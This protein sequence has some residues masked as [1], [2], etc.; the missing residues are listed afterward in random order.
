MKEYIDYLTGHGYNLEAFV[1]GLMIVFDQGTRSRTGKLLQPKFGFLKLVMES[2]NRNPGR[3][4]IFVPV[5]IGYD[6][7]S[8]HCSWQVIET[9][10]YVNELLGTP[11]KKESLFQLANNINILQLK[12]GRVDV[13]FGIPF[14]LRSF[15]EASLVNGKIP[16]NIS[17]TARDNH[18]LQSLGYK[19]L[20]DINQITSIM[21]TALVGTILLTLRGRGVGRDELIRKVKWLKEEIIMRGGKVAES[22]RSSTEIL[23]DRAIDVLKELVGQR[24]DIL[25]SVYYPAKRFEL[26]YYRNQVIH[27]FV[28]EC[29]VAIAMYSVIKVGGPVR[30]QR[31]PIKSQLIGDVTFLSRLLR[32]EFV[33]GSGGINQNLHLTIEKLISSNVVIIGKDDSKPPG[34]DLWV[35]LS[36]EER[37]TGRETFDFYCFLMWPFIETYWLCAVSL[38]TILPAGSSSVFWIDSRIFIDRSQVFGKTLYHEGD[39][40]YF[41][42][43]NKETIENAIGWFKQ[44]GII[45]VHKGI[46]PP[47]SQN[48]EPSHLSKSANTTWIALTKEWYLQIP[49]DCR[50]P[51]ESLPD[52]GLDAAVD[53][54]KNADWKG[55]KGPFQTVSQKYLFDDE[56]SVATT[57]R[58]QRGSLDEYYDDETS[59]ID[60][61]DKLSTM[62]KSS[63]RTEAVREEEEKRVSDFETWNQLKPKGRLWDF[64]ENIGRFRREG[65]NRRDTST[66]AIRVLRLAQRASKWNSGSKKKKA[67]L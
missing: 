49:F 27:L 7:V 63:I 44:L 55:P 20:G 67:K 11:K 37:R 41:E 58:P 26:S 8:L 51:A 56:E 19:L 47:L 60:N 46:E 48:F 24:F 57:H 1:E 9:P 65:K 4:A 23:V 50:I 64:C 17:T 18:L 12:W 39:V 40:S 42:A 62:S 43:V 36:A 45:R 22:G 30:A 54:K 32:F 29:I 25:E 16:Q 59:H 52:S 31:I 10:S 38:Y 61:L 66:V 14:S 28:P 34:D 35:T 21:P 6:K 5:N 15:M 3:D 13:R 2:I 53:E 33:F